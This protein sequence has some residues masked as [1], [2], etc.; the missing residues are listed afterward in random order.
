[1]TK[2]RHRRTWILGMGYEWCYVC[3]AYRRLEPI[4]G[5]SAVP[6]TAWCVPTGD[7]QRNPY[8]Q[9]SQRNDVYL[10]RRLT[11]AFRANRTR[12]GGTPERPRV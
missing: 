1:M 6:I 4:T 2:C 8:A 7:S 11:K 3:G 9:W 10:K 5:N 12:R